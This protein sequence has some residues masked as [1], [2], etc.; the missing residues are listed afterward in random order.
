MCV[1]EQHSDHQTVVQ[2]QAYLQQQCMYVACIYMC[3][4]VYIYM[5]VCIYVCIYIYIYIY[6]VRVTRKIISLCARVRACVRACVRA[7]MYVRPADL[8]QVTNLALRSKTLPN[9]G[10]VVRIPAFHAGGPGSIPVVGKYFAFSSL[11]R[12]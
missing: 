12:P 8:F 5:C 2:Y 3:V 7:S 1:F 6:I 11:P 4:C 10:L 9:P